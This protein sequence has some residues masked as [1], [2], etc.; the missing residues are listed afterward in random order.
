MFPFQSMFRRLSQMIAKSCKYI[1]GLAHHQKGQMSDRLNAIA[2]KVQPYKIVKH[3]QT[4]R[5]HIA[6]KLLECV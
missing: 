1:L 2:L 6:N 5:R 4:I 3:T